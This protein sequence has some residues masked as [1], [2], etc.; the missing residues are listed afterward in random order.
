VGAA[1]GGVVVSDW[2]FEIFID[3]QLPLNNGFIDTTLPNFWSPFIQ[4]PQSQTFA[5][6]KYS[7]S[8]KFANPIKSPSILRFE[9]L[10]AQG[11]GAQSITPAFD[12]ALSFIVYYK[13][14]GE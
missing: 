2:S 5:L 12:I 3:G 6:S 7:N 4:G 11:I 1:I 13:F 8:L 9:V 14:E 10:N